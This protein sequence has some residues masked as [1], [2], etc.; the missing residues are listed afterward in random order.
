MTQEQE[1]DRAETVS[2]LQDLGL[3]E[4]EARCF[5][6]LTQLS[7]GTAKEISELSEVPRTRVYDA[8]RVLEAQG[9]VEVQHSNPQRFRA[10]SVEEAAATLRQKYDTRIDTLQ[11]HLESIDLPSDSDEDDRVQEVWSLTGHEGI[12]SRTFDLLREADSEIVLVV[13]EEAV[14]TDALFE[15]LR[16][17]VERGVNVVVGGITTDIVTR[18]ESELPSVEVFETQIGWL[19]GPNSEDEVAISRLLLTDRTTLLVSSFYPDEDHDGEGLNEQ[20]VFATGL[21]NGVVVLIRR[22]LSTGLGPIADPAQ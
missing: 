3:K 12:Q 2:L 9:L 13:V 11:S 10:V 6:A 1:Q 16:A 18:I 15:Q 22:L 21:G 20:A 17:A 4:Y 8:V 7:T 19:M 14:L 5:M